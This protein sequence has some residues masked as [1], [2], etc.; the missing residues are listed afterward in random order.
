M[1]S[2]E[3]STAISQ[4]SFNKQL[5]RFLGP[6]ETTVNMVGLWHQRPQISPLLTSPALD[7]HKDTFQVLMSFFWNIWLTVGDF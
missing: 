7:S 1:L 6:L 4:L 5:G 3:D 2:P